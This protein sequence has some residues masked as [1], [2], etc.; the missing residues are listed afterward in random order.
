MCE[1]EFVIGNWQNRWCVKYP[2]FFVHFFDAN[3]KHIRSV[4]TQINRR[5]KKLR[6]AAKAK[7]TMYLT[8]TLKNN[9]PY[10]YLPQKIIDRLERYKAMSCGI[11]ENITYDS[12]W[13]GISKSGMIEPTVINMIVK[14]CTLNNVNRTPKGVATEHPYPISSEE[15]GPTQI[16]FNLINSN[17]YN[18]VFTGEDVEDDVDLK[19]NK[20]QIRFAKGGSSVNIINSNGFTLYGAVDSGYIANSHISTLNTSY[21]PNYIP[22]KHLIARNSVI[23]NGNV[24][25][26]HT[27]WQVKPTFDDDQLKYLKYGKSYV[28]DGETKSTK[29]CSASEEWCKPVRR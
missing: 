15:H 11:A 13:L 19:L 16:L 27:R 6:G 3:N 17:I 2:E 29:A 25:G 10:L 1:D 5:I 4:K 9:V 26:V 24:P 8:G 23:R 28:E 20:F 7:V 18:A 21:Y 12:C 14:D 22:V